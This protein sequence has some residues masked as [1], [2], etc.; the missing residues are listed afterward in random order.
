MKE[1]SFVSYI[2]VL[3]SAVEEKE[4]TRKANKEDIKRFI[5]GV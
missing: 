5:G 4:T 3:I 2:N 1:M